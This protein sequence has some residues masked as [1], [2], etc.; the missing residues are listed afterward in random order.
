MEP[1]GAYYQRISQRS[2][3]TVSVC[4]WLPLASDLCHQAARNQLVPLTGIKCPE[5]V[6]PSCWSFLESFT[7][8]LV[9]V[10]EICQL[11]VHFTIYKSG[12]TQK[13]KLLRA[14]TSQLCMEG[15]CCME[16]FKKYFLPSSGFYVYSTQFSILKKQA[17]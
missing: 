16:T 5:Q 12:P 2:G 10:S 11:N 8:H 15:A 3:A 1:S 9:H 13:R 4:S 6:S 14:Q 17:L 7:C